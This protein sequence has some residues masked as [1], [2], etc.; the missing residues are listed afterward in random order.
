[1]HRS[2]WHPEHTVCQRR[3]SWPSYTCRDS[4]C[5][6]VSCLSQSYTIVSVL[7]QWSVDA[8]PGFLLTSCPWPGWCERDD[9]HGSSCHQSP[10]HPGILASFQDGISVPVSWHRN[11]LNIGSVCATPTR[12]PDERLRHSSWWCH[13]A[14]ADWDS[15]PIAAWHHYYQVPW[16]QDWIHL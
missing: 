6:L 10:E 7:E 15:G 14:S 3:A 12:W 8:G 11:H 4:L 2:P 1:M 9:D 5:Q 13:P 16:L